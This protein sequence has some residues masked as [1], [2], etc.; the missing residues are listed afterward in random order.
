LIVGLGQIGLGYDLQLDPALR[1]YSHARA[2]SQHPVFELVGGV[3]GSEKQRALLTNTYGC[4]AYSDLRSALAQ[5]VVDVL[6]IAAPTPLHGVVL[7][8]VLSLGQPKAVLCEKPLS[9]D[10]AEARA[11]VQSCR[12]HGVALYVNY[13]RRSDTA[14]IEIRRRL[15]DNLITGPV[16]GL[17]WYTKGF[18]HN[19]SHFFNLLEYWLGPMVGFQVIDPGRQWDGGDAEPD[20]HISFRNGSVVFMAAREEAFS[21]YTIELLASNGRLRYEQGGQQ[22]QWQAAIPGELRGYTVL[23]GEVESL[24]NGMHRYQWHVAEQLAAAL[25]GRSH[26]LCS[27]AEAL[28]TVENIQSIIDTRAK[29]LAA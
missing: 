13:M 28:V 12:K 17:C 1:V 19:G 18:K 25:G 2:F 22:V 16:K 11:M 8:E 26:H 5:Q 4:P 7:E 10:V 14:A 20:V 9:Y 27:G 23:S 21:H 3:D 24:P 6:I 15:D 29:L